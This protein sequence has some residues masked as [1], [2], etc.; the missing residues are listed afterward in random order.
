MRS[1]RKILLDVRLV[2]S[3][4]AKSA[5]IG[6]QTVVTSLSIS[7]SVQTVDIKAVPTVPSGV[8]TVTLVILAVENA[9]IAMSVL[10]VVTVSAEASPKLMWL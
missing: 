5:T 9:G 2:R 8:T 10:A 3:V 6:A 1:V 4:H 7:C